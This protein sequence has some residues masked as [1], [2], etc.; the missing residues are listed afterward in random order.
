MKKH[1]IKCGRIIIEDFIKFIN[2]EEEK[3]RQIVEV[4]CPY[5]G[6]CEV[7]NAN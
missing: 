3:G 6:F 7:L 1:C 4:E 5:C 2:E